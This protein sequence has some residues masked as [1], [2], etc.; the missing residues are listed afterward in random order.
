MRRRLTTSRPLS[1]LHLELV[2]RITEQIRASPEA[3]GQVLREAPLSRSLSVSRTPV[4]AALRHLVEAGIVAARPRGG[5]VVLR[6]HKDPPDAQSEAGPYAGMLRDIVLKE[7]P[8]PASESWLMRR[9][10]VDRGEIVR[11]LRRLVREGLAEPM[12]GRGW[13]VIEFSSELMTR[14]YHLRIV[15]EPAILCAE[16]Y[17]PDQAPLQA[18]RADHLRALGGL[19][20]RSP[21]EL[22]ELDAAFHEALARGSGN[23]MLVDL[24]RRQNR[25]RR[26]NEYVGYSRPERVRSSLL[27]HVAIIDRVLVGDCVSAAELLRAHLATSREQ[28][29]THFAADLARIRARGLSLPNKTRGR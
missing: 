22:F 8:Q 25:L 14:S 29:L 16:S 2:S 13:S 15:L 21:A 4:R 19:E 3:V 27:E 9:Y 10:G 23:P 20:S 28:T 7:I 11:A 5:Y 1:D 26:L 18:L 12:P 6:N 24:I 17:R